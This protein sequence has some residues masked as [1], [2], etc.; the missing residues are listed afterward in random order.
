MVVRV[1]RELGKV[2]SGWK[3]CGDAKPKESMTVANTKATLLSAAD[4]MTTL[5]EMEES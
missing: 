1:E 4:A 3:D 2:E 5:P